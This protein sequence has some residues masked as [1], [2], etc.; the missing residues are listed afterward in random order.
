[1]MLDLTNWLMMG[2]GLLIWWE[3]FLEYGGWMGN[4]A[5]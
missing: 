3:I 5:T 2:G 4:S 1:M